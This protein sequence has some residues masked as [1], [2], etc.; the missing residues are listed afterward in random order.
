MPSDV[1][2]EC[3]R[4]L[5]EILLQLAGFERYSRDCQSRSPADAALHQHLSQLAGGA[6]HLFEQ[7]LQRV[8][9]DEGL[10]LPG[11]A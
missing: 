4:H 2:C 10:V 8:M 6:R 7:A 5:A 1:A 3:P 11:G 9:V